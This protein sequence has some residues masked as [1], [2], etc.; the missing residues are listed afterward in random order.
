MIKDLFNKNLPEPL[1]KAAVEVISVLTGNGFE[2]FLVGGC[3]RDLILGKTATDLDITTNAKP[4]QVQKIFRRTIPTGI[5]H[6]TVTVLSGRIPVEVTTYRSESDYSDGRR[7]DQV[8]FSDTIEEDLSR[9]DFTINALAY[10]PVDDVLIDL[11]RGKDDIGSRL[12]RTIGNPYERFYEDGLRPVRAC[13][14]RATLNFEIESSTYEA[15]CREEVQQRTGLVAVER[16]TDELFKGLRSVPYL[17]MTDALM[18]SGLLY[19]FIDFSECSPQSVYE[20]RDNLE[21][22]CDSDPVVKVSLFFFF[23]FG[24]LETIVKTGRS[25][26]FSN[27][28]LKFLEI[29]YTCWNYLF[30]PNHLTDLNSGETPNE[31]E[32]MA[33]W[34]QIYKEKAMDAFSKMEQAVTA[35]ESEEVY[36]NYMRILETAV[37]TP[38]DLAINGNDLMSLGITGKQ[39]G[40]VFRELIRTFLK[41]PDQITNDKESLLHL[42]KEYINYPDQKT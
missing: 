1:R 14:F 20:N 22:I 38:A 16:F 36:Q 19:R 10:N 21:L 25:L 27:E 3:V 34:K 26:K 17:R 23:L 18:Q 11:F 32:R 4:K 13:R 33:V 7:P 15:V 31:Y 42:A 39:I 30:R 5:Q 35:F 9:R 12:I 8:Q 2:A 6:G 37:L 41:D 24:R 28:Q 29:S 40:V